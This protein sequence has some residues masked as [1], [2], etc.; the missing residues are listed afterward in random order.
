MYLDTDPIQIGK[1]GSD[2]DTDTYFALL[3]DTVPILFQILFHSTI[4]SKRLYKCTISLQG[5]A[6]LLS[7]LKV[8]HCF[9]LWHGLSMP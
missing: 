8:L 2:T 5:K 4:L 1:V 7:A 6:I 9:P 3:R